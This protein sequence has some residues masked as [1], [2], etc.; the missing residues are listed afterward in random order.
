MSNSKTHINPRRR[1]IDFERLAEAILDLAITI[2]DEKA[3]DRAKEI[4][5]RM[6]QREAGAA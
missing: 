5:R 1:D 3:Q 6:S 4:R 2:D